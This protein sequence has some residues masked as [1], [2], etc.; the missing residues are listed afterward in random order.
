[1]TPQSVSA[2][3][4]P[5]RV[6]LLIGILVFLVLMAGSAFLGSRLAMAYGTSKHN[7]TP[8]SCTYNA[9]HQLI[10]GPSYCAQSNWSCVGT[11]IGGCVDGKQKVT[12]SGTGCPQKVK[13]LTCNAGG[14]GNGYTLN[15]ATLKCVRDVQSCLAP[16]TPDGCVPH[17]C[18]KGYF[19][20]HT[21]C[22]GGVYDGGHAVV[23]GAKKV[24]Y[25]STCTAGCS[26]PPVHC[27]PDG[28]LTLHFL[29]CAGNGIGKFDRTNS[30][31]SVVSTSTGKA[32]RCDTSG[33]TPTSG[34][35]SGT[36]PTQ[37][38]GSGGSCQ[39]TVITWG[40]VH[41]TGCS[42][43]GTET[44]YQSWDGVNA[45]GVTSSGT[46]PVG[47]HTSSTCQPTVRHQ[48]AYAKPGYAQKENCLTS[49]QGGYADCSGWSTPYYDTYDC[50]IPTP[51]G[52]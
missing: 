33:T 52:Y 23:S 10:S 34:S 38:S 27:T 26:T 47:Q 48:C 29:G 9:S 7:S 51:V 30:C 25:A 21:F 46:A 17:Q 22:P 13:Y 8:S 20:P 32:T 28:T 5:R 49:P 40:A 18:H 45:C 35:G 39:P 24:A 41:W 19:I 36:T 42:A 4:T 37:G 11:D 43:Q 44:G 12:Y 14:C 2:R 50:P 1:M 16:S 6:W 15:T 31:G 3:R